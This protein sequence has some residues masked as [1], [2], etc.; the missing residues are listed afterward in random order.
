M[1]RRAYKNKH[2]FQG[3][4]IKKR[5]LAVCL[6]RSMD[7]KSIIEREGGEIGEERNCEYYGR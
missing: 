5:K 7:L 2:H 6:R 3:S 1:R 4:S